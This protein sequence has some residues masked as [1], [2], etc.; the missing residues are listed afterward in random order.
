MRSR[1]SGADAASVGATTSAT[2]TAR[3]PWLFVLLASALPT[4]M[5]AAERIARS[6]IRRRT[7][8][9]PLGQQMPRALAGLRVRGVLVVDG[10]PVADLA[11]GDQLAT[12][13]GLDQ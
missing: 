2:D 13:R 7:H 1:A 5:R 4:R 12:G 10:Q 11:V 8:D 3:T 6:G 9:G